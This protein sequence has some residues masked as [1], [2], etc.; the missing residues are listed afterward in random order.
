MTEREIDLT[1]NYI[2]IYGV[3]VRL[4]CSELIIRVAKSVSP[5]QIMSKC[6]FPRIP[7]LVF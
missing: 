3:F 5:R 4:D 6:Y 1:L 2:N 7:N